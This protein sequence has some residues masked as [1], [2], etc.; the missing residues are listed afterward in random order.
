MSDRDILEQMIKSEARI[1][2]HE[3]GGSK[4][5]VLKEPQNPRTKVEILGM[6]P[7][8]VVIKTDMF[9]SPD[10]LLN[11]KMGIRKRAD[12]AIISAKRKCILYV[13]MKKS[14]KKRKH[15]V[16]QLRGAKCVVA[17]CREVGRIFWNEE[18]FLLGYQDRYI[19]V[20]HTSTQ[21]KKTRMNTSRSKGRDTPK[22]MH[23]VPERAM[24]VGHLYP[25]PFDKIAGL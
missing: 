12:Y 25:L 2:L 15:I 24:K 21:Y 9:G 8:S 10:S 7:D 23:D 18:S 13:E 6:P 3:K 22:A 1:G 4:S 17:Y 14:N 20:G 19:S 16:S 11:D 5:V